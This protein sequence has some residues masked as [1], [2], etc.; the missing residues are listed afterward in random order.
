MIDHHPVQGPRLVLH[1]N[2]HHDTIHIRAIH[3]LP[4]DSTA[5]VDSEHSAQ[6]HL[7]PI[8][9]V[10]QMASQPVF[11]ENVGRALF[12][13]LFVGDLRAS[14][15]RARQNAAEARSVLTLELRFDR[16]ALHVARYPWELLHDG[17]RFVLADQAINLVRSVPFAA[18]F[19]PHTPET[20][21]PL[22]MLL[23]E[24]SSDQQA[25]ETLQTTLDP[26][27]RAGR[28][29]L[30]YLMPP[31]WDA[32][33]DWLL[34]GAPDVLHFA[35][36]GDLAPLGLIFEGALGE[37]DSVAAGSLGD[38]FYSTR[39]RLAVLSATAAASKSHLG[40]VAPTL[41]AAGIPAVVAIQQHL[42]E[43][44]AQQF[45]QRFYAALLSGRSIETAHQIG[46]RQLARSTFWHLP[47]L[48]VRAVTAPDSDQAL[49][50]VWIDTAT[51]QIVPLHESFR[52]G[53]WLRESGTPPTG[54]AVR[55]LIG[56][57]VETGDS[58][59]Q[60][61]QITPAAR[62]LQAGPVTI[63]I[64]APGCEVYETKRTLA[65][66]AQTIMPPVWLPITP[67]QTGSLAIH[68]ALV[69][70]DAVIATVTHSIQVVA[71]DTGT[72]HTGY[73]RVQSRQIDTQPDTSGV[74]DDW[75]ASSPENPER[76][77]GEFD[78]ISD[79]PTLSP[80]DVPDQPDDRSPRD[81]SVIHAAYEPER[82]SLHDQ[83]EPDADRQDARAKTTDSVQRET[84]DGVVDWL[85]AGEQPVRE[86]DDPMIGSDE[87]ILFEPFPL[88]DAIAPTIQHVL[89]RDDDA[90]DDDA[91]QY[92]TIIGDADD[93]TLILDI[94]QPR[95]DSL[96]HFPDDEQIDWLKDWNGGA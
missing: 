69:Q 89:A 1:L 16:A 54:E 94:E 84:L 50:N 39:L 93:P 24:A 60:F 27:Q 11:H 47:T 4:G 56:C 34:A 79:I 22:D 91:D 28:L 62:A 25:F 77:S 32:L 45:L 72:L 31:T 66:W 74:M 26:A 71:H 58:A 38:A 30:A 83:R 19:P 88:D 51:P 65:I 78:S 42:P 81:S 29:D 73:A 75:E 95:D 6:I 15:A 82:E 55:R 40:A 85:Q 36:H 64:S 5:R 23:T 52:I 59:D 57:A 68:V 35:G 70:G 13:A 63:E 41:V 10:W 76:Q 43:A 80:G 53:V 17:A 21:R 8:D 33:M 9:D 48:T 87:F 18:P 14:F 49:S 61:D 67:R 12:R 92:P 3:S 86:I 37:P 46:R 20:N 90:A 2:A 7:P 96:E 44:A